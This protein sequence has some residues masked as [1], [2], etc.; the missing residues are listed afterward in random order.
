MLCMFMFY[1]TTHHLMGH[2][3]IKPKYIVCIYVWTPF[4]YSVKTSITL[5]SVCHY[6]GAEE[7]F[8][9]IEWKE[10][11]PPLGSLSTHDSWQLPPSAMKE[12]ILSCMVWH[13]MILRRAGNIDHCTHIKSNTF[14]Y[15]L[16]FCQKKPNVTRALGSYSCR[17]PL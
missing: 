9:K 2:I 10:I 16:G 13:L 6:H 8:L 14:F 3:K 4:S 7:V 15:L 1:C 17:D 12:W 11:P 5:C